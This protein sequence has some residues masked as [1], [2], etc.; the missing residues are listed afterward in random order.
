MI[1][2]RSI[3][4]SRRTLPDYHIH[5]FLRDQLIK[6][7]DNSQIARSLKERPPKSANEANQRIATLLS[8]EAGSAGRYSENFALDDDDNVHFGYDRRF[9]GSARK[10]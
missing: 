7:A 2:R 9:G 3:F 1:Y 5:R 8:S 4:N 10:N 6:S